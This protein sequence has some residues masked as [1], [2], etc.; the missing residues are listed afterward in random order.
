MITPEEL[1]G[2]Q[3][4]IN[5]VKHGAPLVP[6][7]GKRVPPGTLGRPSELSLHAWAG[8]GAE[9][10]RDAGA[11][12]FE[13]G[14]DGSGK[15]KH[16]FDTAV[17]GKDYEYRE[18]GSRD[19]LL[20]LQV[21][22]HGDQYAEARHRSPAQQLTVLHA[23]PASLHHSLDF[24]ASQLASELSRHRFIEKNAHPLAGLR[25]PIPRPQRLAHA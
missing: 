9:V 1:W 19:V 22:I 14:K 16:R 21:A 5:R 20:M 13:C 17:T 15:R 2:L 25:G 10:K 18:P 8:S 11:C 3:N 7:N 24:V 6:H 23:S 12:L 4:G